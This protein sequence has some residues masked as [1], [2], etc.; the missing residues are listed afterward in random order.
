MPGQAGPLPPGTST[1]LPEGHPPI[2]GRATV[3][4]GDDVRF[5]GVVRLRGKLASAPE[6]YVFISVK[7]EGIRM[8]A[9]S[10]RYALADAEPAVDGV[11]RL[12]FDLD[13]TNM[14]G[15]LVPGALVLEARF[16]PDGIVESR[17]GVVT[18]SVPT[19]V[20]DMAAEID[21]DS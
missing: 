18:A 16:D 13:K 21:L 5:G 11:R 4:A 10:R 20:G 12:P 1:E 2:G 6:G 14:M 3:D 17:E 7:P 8:P 19:K 15:G 9:F